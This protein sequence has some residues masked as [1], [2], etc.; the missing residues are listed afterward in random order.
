MIWIDII[1]MHPI[2]R[3]FSVITTIFGIGEVN[4]PFLAISVGRCQ[5]FRSNDATL[6]DVA[7]VQ[8][9]LFTF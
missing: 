4:T 6:K 8:N 9:Y 1:H 7:I 5:S 2:L 3:K